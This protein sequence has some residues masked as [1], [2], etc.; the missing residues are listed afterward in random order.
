[1][2]GDEAGN[3]GIMWFGEAKPC[4]WV[5][6]EEDVRSRIERYEL[7][8][9]GMKDERGE[10]LVLTARALKTALVGYPRDGFDLD[11]KL[12]WIRDSR[13]GYEEA[14]RGKEEWRT[15]EG[16]GFFV[17]TASAVVGQALLHCFLVFLAGCEQVTLPWIFQ[18]HVIDKG[19]GLRTGSQ[20]NFVT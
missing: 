3:V 1:M 14:Y 19:K 12:I 10:V 13:G 11:L 7:K 9:G 2:P 17:L 18:T 6:S 20:R 15:D 16:R 5:M 8:K 4:W